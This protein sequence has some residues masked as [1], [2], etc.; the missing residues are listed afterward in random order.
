[1]L[2]YD[3]LG[4][5]LIRIGN[6]DVDYDMAGT[7]VRRIGNL[8]VDYDRFGTRPR[9]LRSEAEAQLDEQMSVIVFLIL[10]A[11]NSDD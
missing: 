6:M 10:V 8:T 4:S 9:C 11:F 7:R 1:M 2:E 3:K 5:R